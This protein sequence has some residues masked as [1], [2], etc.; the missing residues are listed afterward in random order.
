MPADQGR[1]VAS[2]HQLVSPVLRHH[3]NLGLVR[4][5]PQIHSAFDFAADDVTVDAVAQI[6]M[7]LKHPVL[8]LTPRTI[9]RYPHTWEPST[10]VPNWSRRAPAGALPA[11]PWSSLTVVTIFCIPA[12]S[13]CW[14]ALVRLAAS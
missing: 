12:T 13:G 11:R 8:I 6:L 10:L 5:I 4:Q 7:R 2:H 1:P 9:K 14:N 3:F